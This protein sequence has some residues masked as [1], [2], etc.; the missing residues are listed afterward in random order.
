MLAKQAGRLIKDNRVGNR[1]R[2][3]ELAR[4]SGVSRTILS[5]LENG[6][7]QPVQTNVLDR[8]FAALD[9]TPR[10]IADLGTDVGRRQARLEH[11]MKLEQRRSR[12]LR[13]GIRLSADKKAAPKLIAKARKQVELWR[14]KSSCSL[15][16]IE[17]WSDF[18]NLSPRQ[19]A[20][21]MAEFGEWEDAM[22]QNSPWTWTWN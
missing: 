21:A 19:M 8:I 13:L 12:H 1:W 7:E 16:Y 9:I 22:F 5:H 6:H 10:L 4:V 18:L 17:R 3:A 15:F 11:R 20:H 2:Q 14:R